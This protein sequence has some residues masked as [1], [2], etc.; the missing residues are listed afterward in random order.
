MIAELG[1][2]LAMDLVQRHRTQDPKI[3]GK[4]VRWCLDVTV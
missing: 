1:E 2:E 3:T 4:F